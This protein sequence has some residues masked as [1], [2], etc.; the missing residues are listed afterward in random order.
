VLDRVP[1]TGVAHDLVV[2]PAQ[3][4]CFDFDYFNS[5]APALQARMLACAKS[6]IDNPDSGMGAYAIQP[7]DY[8]V[9]TPYLDACIRKYHKVPAGQKHVND[10]SL[11]GVEGLP[12]DGQLDVTKLGLSSLSMRVRTG[13]NLKAFPLPGGMS[14]QD[15]CDMENVMVDAFS[16]L[17]KDPAYGGRYV[18]LTPGH[19]CEISEDEYKDLVKAHIMFKDMADDPYLASAGIASDWPYG[20]GCYISEDKQFIVWVGE[21]DHLRIMCMKKGTL[22][23]EVFDRLSS[24]I[25]TMDK[26]AAFAYHLR[27][28]SIQTGILT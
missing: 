1:Q 11:D 4:A 27:A 2:L 5:L 8:D 26:V 24:S 18:S 15:R 19:R 17:I 13:R 23:N 12:A 14:K 20:R 6:G 3:I 21:E 25:K 22:L 10:W 16:S 9:L 7:D 28:I